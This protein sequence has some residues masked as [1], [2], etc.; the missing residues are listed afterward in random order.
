MFAWER[1]VFRELLLTD[2][3]VAAGMSSLAT[4]GLWCHVWGEGISSPTTVHVMLIIKSHISEATWLSEAAQHMG[5]ELFFPP[6][7]LKWVFPAQPPKGR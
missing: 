1:S 7:C 6:A 2:G 5:M 3:D 4:M